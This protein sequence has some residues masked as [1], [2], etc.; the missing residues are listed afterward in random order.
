MGLLILVL[1][2]I[3]QLV[4]CY[5]SSS[6]GFDFIHLNIVVSLVCGVF[7][8]TVGTARDVRDE[9]DPLLV[10]CKVFSGLSTYFLL[11]P[12]VW[13][14]GESVY[15]NYF[16]GGEIR[17]HIIM[18]ALLFGFCWLF[19]A[20][21]VLITGVAAGE[22]T[23]ARTGGIA[24]CWLSAVGATYMAFFT[25]VIIIAVLSAVFVGILLLRVFWLRKKKQLSS[26]EAAQEKEALPHVWFGIIT[27]VAVGPL[28]VFSWIF[29]MAYY[30][31]P[32][33]AALGWLY[34]IIFVPTCV[35][36]FLVF[37]VYPGYPLLRKKLSKKDDVEKMTAGETSGSAP[38]E[39]TFTFRPGEGKNREGIELKENNTSTDK[40]AEGSNEKS[41]ESDMNHQTDETNGQVE[42]AAQLVS[43]GDNVTEETPSSDHESGT[44]KAPEKANNVS[45]STDPTKTPEDVPKESKTEEGTTEDLS[46]TPKNDSESSS[47]PTAKPD[48]SGDPPKA[49]S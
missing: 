16:Y 45:E 23:I 29:V 13:V 46:A 48:A 17:F 41:N 33:N 36:I 35:V 6:R 4:L 39:N 27:M 34:F 31:E 21:I 32:T 40:P 42:S 7:F 22:T 47:P 1:S 10:T 43:A 37:V 2:S 14:M 49:E 11:V 20:L 24:T 9:T 19:P 18:M 5:F 28:L 44:D 15:L 25:P 30:N 12:L 3:L 26:E 8:L 38:S